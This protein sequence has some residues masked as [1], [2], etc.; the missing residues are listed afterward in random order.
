MG[1]EHSGR[2]FDL[3]IR[4]LKRENAGESGPRNDAGAL[5]K[6]QDHDVAE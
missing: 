3:N 4:W 5:S 2:L 1:E 6:E